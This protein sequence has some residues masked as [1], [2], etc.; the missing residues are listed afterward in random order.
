M[1]GTRVT[2]AAALVIVGT[3]AALLSIV[4][5]LQWL[6]LA[7]AVTA[8]GALGWSVFRQASESAVQRSG[9]DALR[10]RNIELEG[11]V[12]AGA[13]DASAS[14]ERLRSI[15]DSA[16]DGII[17]IDPTGRI[18]SFNPAAE[19]LFGYPAS[20]VMGRNVSMLMPSPYQEE[21]DGYLK[22]YLTTGEARIIGI[23]REVTGR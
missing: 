9:L 1:F 19:R 7:V 20:E 2:R 5:S 8:I 10:R 12:E 14:G 13:A 22:R 15:I 18:E 6:S 4:P 3:A 23:G 21:H 16:V 17:V 11:Q